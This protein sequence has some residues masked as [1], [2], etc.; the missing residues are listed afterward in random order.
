MEKKPKQEYYTKEGLEELKKELNRLKTEETRKISELIRQTASFGDLKENFAYHDA[1]D[2]QAFLQGKIAE[3]D[4]KIR[5]SI[6]VEKGNSDKVQVGSKVSLLFGEEKM[7][8]YI[9]STDLVD[10][11]NGKISYESPLG[12]ALLNK[13]VGDKIEFGMDE[14][15]VYRILKIE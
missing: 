14:K 13:R 11:L 1:K 8:I 6:I 2:K 9:V 12:K 3:L 7:D 15:T 4:G 10:P 5:N